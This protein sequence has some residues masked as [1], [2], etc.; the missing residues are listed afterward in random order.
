[1]AGGVVLAPFLGIAVEPWIGALR[2]NSQIAVIAATAA[3]C[4]GAAL[5]GAIRLISEYENY[6]ESEQPAPALYVDGLDLRYQASEPLAGALDAIRSNTPRST[7]I[8]A[9]QKDYYLPTI[10]QRTLFTNYFVS[11][12]PSGI[13]L[14]L[15]YLLFYVKGYDQSQIADRK[16]SAENIF[17]GASDE[18]RLGA[19]NNI[20]ALGRPVAF[21]VNRATQSE[22]EAWFS[23][24][25]SA[26]AIHEDSGHSVWLVHPQ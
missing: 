25:S 15:N 11:E 7:L 3:L 2:K 20:L 8:V 16:E 1:M 12:R 19:L 26:A 18:I 24:L 4:L 23:G 13:G 6:E 5:P 17:Y 10:A 21:I 22:T 14:K 9:T